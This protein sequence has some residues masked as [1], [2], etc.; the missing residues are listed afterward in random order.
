MPLLMTT[1]LD[2]WT[3]DCMPL[4]MDKP[5]S[6]PEFPSGSWR[7]YYHQ[8]GQNHSLF[9]FDLKFTFADGAED[10]QVEGSGLDNVGRYRITGCCSCRTGRLGLCKKYIR[11]TGDPRE[12]KGHCVEYKGVVQ[13]SLAAGVQGKW[14]VQTR[15]Y[16]GTGDFHI[17]P[18]EQPALVATAVP[19]AMASEV[20]P[21]AVPVANTQNKC[22]VCFKPPVNTCLR[23]CGHVAVCSTCSEQRKQC[24][25]CRAI[26][27]SVESI[28]T[29]QEC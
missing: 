29:A 20:L 24:P 12:N 26:I 15:T 25:I 14:S 22:V 18:E 11:G 21:M 23:P 8:Y 2:Q 19:I 9:C 10:G 1:E 6:I 17:W 13:G 4:Y 3:Q 16:S 5:T 7:G 28:V 27:Q